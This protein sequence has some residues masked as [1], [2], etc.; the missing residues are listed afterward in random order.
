MAGRL[1]AAVGCFESILAEYPTDLLALVFLQSELFWLGDMVRS[2]RVSKTLV[3]H[4]NADVP[5]FAAFLAIRA[6]DLEEKNAFDEAEQVA[7]QALTLNPGDVWGAHA[8]AHVMLMQNRIDEGI[9]W[10][11]ER[12][13]LWQDAN[14]MQF[15]LAW[16]QCLFLAERKQHDQMLNIYDTRIRNR[17]HPLLSL[18]HI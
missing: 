2:E 3:S 9:A 5:G 15:H 4:W 14:Q 8:L 17:H 10:M 11:A 16:H 18:I 12:E 13:P 1:E 6:F 7:Q